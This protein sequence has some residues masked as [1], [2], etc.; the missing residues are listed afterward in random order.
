M[1]LTVAVMTLLV[2]ALVL[3][4]FFL[5]NQYAVYRL[6]QSVLPPQETTASTTKAAV[7]PLP[8]NVPSNEDRH[9]THETAT[10]EILTSRNSETTL[11]QGETVRIDDTV[12]LFSDIVEDSRCPEGMNCKVAGEVIIEL[13]V[14]RG[15]NTSFIYLSSLTGGRPNRPS[16]TFTQKYEVSL[17]ATQYKNEVGVGDGGVVVAGYTIRFSSVTPGTPSSEKPIGIK[18]SDYT[19]TLDIQ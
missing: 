10:R 13:A 7:A 3:L 16:T 1:L 8:Q 12:I 14:R 17:A 5:G 19:V 9:Y 11:F 4:A 18:K 2:A 6:S 15:T